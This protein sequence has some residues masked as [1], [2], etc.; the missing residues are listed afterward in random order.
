MSPNE[1]GIFR[2]AVA[3]AEELGFIATVID[4]DPWEERRRLLD[5]GK[6]DV[7]WICGLP[8]VRLADE[9]QPRFELIAAPVPVGERYL[10][11]PVYFSDIVV[12]AESPVRSFEDLRGAAF[13]YNEPSSHSGYEV[14]KYHL[15]A[16]GYGDAF[17]GDIV[18]SGSH[19]ASIEMILRGEVDTACVDTMVLD[20]A[21][22]SRPEFDERLRVVNTIGPSPVPPIIASLNLHEEVR[23]QL[24][25]ALTGLDGTPRGR[26]ILHRAGPARFAA[27]TDADYDE[28]RR[29]AAL[30][31]TITL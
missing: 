4:V 21:R 22:K 12:R 15:A 14:M 8:Y 11:R 7:A 28:I 30:A 1:D 27:V 20:I 25:E 16:G 5:A 6:I 17:F 24:R 18:E 13:A 26:S 2:A 19:L 3:A 23:L 9:P 10:D 31:D 29:M